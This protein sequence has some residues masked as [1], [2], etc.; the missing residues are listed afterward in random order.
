MNTYL[1]F[2]EL[3][4]FCYFFPILSFFNPKSFVIFQKLGSCKIHNEFKEPGREKISSPF[5]IFGPNIF[6]NE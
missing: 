6:K 2:S 4:M 3:G 5:R 1:F